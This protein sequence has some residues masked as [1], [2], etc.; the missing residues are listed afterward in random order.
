MAEI[1]SITILKKVIYAYIG[2]FVSKKFQ[3]KLFFTPFNRYEIEKSW[4]KNVLK[5]LY[6]SSLILCYLNATTDLLPTPSIAFTGSRALRNF[7]YIATIG[8][9]CTRAKSLF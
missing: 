5:H 3:G 6:I 8:G 7:L 9:D 2:I 1:V 4:Q